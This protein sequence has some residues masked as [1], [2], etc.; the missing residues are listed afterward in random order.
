MRESH[1]GDAHSL[2]HCFID[3]SCDF[4]PFRTL[5]HPVEEVEV[6]V[7]V[8]RE[9]LPLVRVTVFGVYLL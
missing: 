4:G 9:E 3:L 7:L 2:E 6:Q 1:A 8:A 5:E